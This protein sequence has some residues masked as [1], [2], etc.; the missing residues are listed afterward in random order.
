MS[1]PARTNRPDPAGDV[2]VVLGT[3]PEAIKLAPVV[4][5]LGPR[6]RLVHT[7]QHF[8]QH[9][10][11]AILDELPGMRIQHHIS[12]GGRSR[13]EQ[14]GSATEQLSRYLAEHPARALVVQGDTN[15]TLAGALAAN[16]AAVPV[17]HVEAGLRSDDRSMPEE[18]NRVLVDAAADLCCAPVQANAQRLRSEGI[19][20]DRIAV[21][22]NTLAE[23]L[24]L[25]LPG[26]DG[27]HDRLRQVGVADD[28]FVLCTLHRAGT[29]DD[30][31]ALAAMT[32]ALAR[33]AKQVTV[34]LPLHPRTRAKLTQFGLTDTLGEVRVVAPVGPRDFLSLEA[35]AA[36][37]VSDSG[38]VQ[39]EAALL[40]RPL[41]VLRDSTER[42]ELLDG[43]CRLLGSSDPASAVLRAWQ[44]APQWAQDLAGRQLPYPP[45]SAG[46][47]I[48]A[49]I[50]RRWPV[51]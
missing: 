13:G 1:G 26:A 3:R 15:S 19:P 41:L 17:V 18:T 40:R 24:E 14:I 36:L 10:W 43:W 11:G 5:A 37:I 47:R 20:E 22:G 28:P 42:P 39:E 8:D 32:D 23:A 44:D 51:A 25:L 34:L 50:E 9:L 12:V 33:L 21:T 38:G 2:L 6:A 31:R 4:R 27:R 29:V 30:P 7:G 16:C 35:A 49:Q 48:V 45:G 46:Q